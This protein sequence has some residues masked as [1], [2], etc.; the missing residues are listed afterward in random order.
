MV[1]LG[2]AG[3]IWLV[4]MMGAGQSTVGPALADRLERRFIDTDAEIERVTGATIPAIF[5]RE[6]EAGFRAHESRAIG[7]VAGERAVVSVGGGA[8]TVA[9]NLERMEASGVLV[10]LRA[11]A[12]TLAERT[13]DG[14]DRPLLAGLDAAGRE[15]RLAALLA[16]RRAAY[17]RARVVVDVDGAPVGQVVEEILKALEEPQ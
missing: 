8:L 10:H 16:E 1:D 12:A 4:G 13:A 15:A 14:D 6:G 9:A 5:E 11:S 17:E 2:G 3:T 7:A